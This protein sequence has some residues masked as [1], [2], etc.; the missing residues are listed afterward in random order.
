MKRHI[1]QTVKQLGK[2]CR[3][4]RPPQRPVPSHGFQLGNFLQQQPQSGQNN[5]HRGNSRLAAKGEPV[6]LG[7]KRRGTIAEALVGVEWINHGVASQSD[8]RDRMI[9]DDR[10]SVLC[11]TKS[12]IPCFGADNQIGVRVTRGHS[13]QPLQQT[14]PGEEEKEHDDGKDPNASDDHRE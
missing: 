2:K 14:A 8:S 5:Q 13:L 12:G 1:D 4:K 7:M 9:R 10:Q 11:N 6:A 3:E